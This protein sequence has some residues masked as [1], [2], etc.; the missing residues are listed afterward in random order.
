MRLGILIVLGLM[1]FLLF[2][3]RLLP[4]LGVQLGRS[5]RKPFRQAKWMWASMA[6]SEEELVRAEEEFG[7]ECAR[8]FAGQFRGQAARAEAGVVAEVGARLA[9]ASSSGRQFAFQTV[10]GP[11]ENAYALPGGFVFVSDSL[12]TL[13]ERQADE[14]AFFLAHEMGHVVRGHVRDRVMVEQILQKVTARAGGA[15]MLLQKLLSKGYSREQELEADLYAARL[16]KKAGFRPEG[17]VRVL[18]RLRGR[19]PEEGGLPEYFASHPPVGERIRELER[20]FAA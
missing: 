8:E 19:H 3:A 16:A 6:G 18:E 2:G 20:E 17:G 15:G 1:I 9:G 13:C 11:V 12:V 7:E 5:A 14:V 4:M 10:H